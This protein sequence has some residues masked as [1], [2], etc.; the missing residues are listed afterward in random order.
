MK[1][2]LENN[3]RR[4]TIEDLEKQNFGNPDEAP[5]TMIKRCLLLCKTPIDQFSVEDLRLMIGQSFSLRYLIPQ[6]IEHLKKDIL[7]EGDF[8]P[9]DLLK[10]VLSVDGTFWTENKQLWQTVKELINDK[11][12]EIAI[13]KISTVMFDRA[14][15]H[16]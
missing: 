13:E 16:R 15:M 8:Y 6:A 5:T 10:N 14:A 1:P 12:E 3:W 2:G 11:R 4:K 9:G 7:V